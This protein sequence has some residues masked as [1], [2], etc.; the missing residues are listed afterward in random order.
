MGKNRETRSD[1][2]IDC[3][4]TINI[5]LKECV[6]RLS[7]ITNTPV[8][9]I[10]EKIVLTGL[11]S[12]RVT[13]L[14]SNYFKRDYE[15]KN[16]FYIGKLENPSLQKREKREVTERITIRF[17]QEDMNLIKSLAYSLDVTPSRATSLLLENTILETNFI[18]KFAK[19]HLK[20]TL[21]EG[22]IREL[23]KVIL[24]INQNNPYEEKIS[25]AS[26]LS[27]FYD[28]LKG[29]AM[30]MNKAIINWIEKVK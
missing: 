2:K 3:K 10:A 29:S 30:N 21:D 11:D 24:Y 5:G 26:L 25:W 15:M 23:K 16:T 1:K 6:Y 8:K 7:Y 20:E 9:D 17:K 13:E 14:F 28:E 27:Y 19:E 22:R 12:K 4:P 18:N